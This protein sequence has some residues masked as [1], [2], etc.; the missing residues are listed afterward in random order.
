[1]TAKLDWDF[2]NCDSTWTAISELHDDGMYHAWRI[3]VCEDGTF[4]INESDDEL[5]DTHSSCFDTLTA[6]KEYCTKR[7]ETLLEEA[8]ARPKQVFTRSYVLNKPLYTVLLYDG[9]LVTSDNEVWV[10]FSK[11]EADSQA[12][13]HEGSRVV[14]Y[15]DYLE[16]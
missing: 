15:S 1:M 4:T 11:S 7:E 9:T 16:D 13:M 8:E 12:D 14:Q 2:D 10:T 6:A 5:L 3:T